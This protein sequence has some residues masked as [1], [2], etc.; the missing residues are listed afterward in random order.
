MVVSDRDLGQADDVR[1]AS[2]GVLR[3]EDEDRV[4]VHVP[5]MDGGC[6]FCGAPAGDAGANVGN[7]G[8]AS[9]R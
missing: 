4:E 1:V 7:L 8:R 9:A 3:M 6:A 5:S 2:V